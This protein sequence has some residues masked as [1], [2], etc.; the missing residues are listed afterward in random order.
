MKPV[1]LTAIVVALV[2]CAWFALGIRQAHDTTRAQAILSA[3]RPL[4]QAEAHQAASL[5][6]HAGVLNPDREVQVLRGRL[7]LVQGRKAEALS[8]LSAVTQ[9]EP[10]SRE[11]WLWVAQAALGQNEPLLQRALKTIFSIDPPP[12]RAR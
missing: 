4:S 11:A 2:S 6:D 3:S 5:L 7:A 8:I 1:R 9:A 10:R 12:P